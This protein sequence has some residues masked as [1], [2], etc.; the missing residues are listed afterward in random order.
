MMTNPMA[1]PTIAPTFGWLTISMDAADEE[2]VGVEAGEEEEVIGVYIADVVE[3]VLVQY[4]LELVLVVESDLLCVDVDL[5]DDVGSLEVFETLL[6]EREVGSVEVDR[7]VCPDV[8]LVTS[9]D[10]SAVVVESIGIL[11]AGNGT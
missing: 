5:L 11:S 10:E 9:L 6:E 7:M 2:M 1:P 8:V 4:E 3:A